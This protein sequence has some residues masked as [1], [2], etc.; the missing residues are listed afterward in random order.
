MPLYSSKCSEC[1]TAHTYV[2]TVANRAETPLCCD[3][4]TFKTLDTPMVSAMAWSGWKGFN[5]PGGQWIEDGA[6]YKKFL[7]KNNYVPASEGHQEAAIQRTNQA[8]ADDK[9]LEAAVTQAV[10]ANT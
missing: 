5:V 1:G 8:A 9:K 4:Q 2:K 6:A 7:D 3:V 10:M